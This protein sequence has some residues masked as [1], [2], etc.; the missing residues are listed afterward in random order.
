MQ[1]GNV[2]DKPKVVQFEITGRDNA[3]LQRFYEGLFGW[4]LQGR[5]G[6]RRTSASETGLPGAVGSTRSGPNG[7]RD[8]SWDGGGGQVTVY[9]EV[10]DVRKSA[11]TAEELG[12]TV[13]APPY[14]VPGRELTLAFIADPEGHVVGLAQG[15]QSAIEQAGYAR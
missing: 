15:L 4:E 12:G 6:Y 2:V 13:I 5:E 8:E 1:E 7:G 10:A 11:A 3:A 9:V 14:D